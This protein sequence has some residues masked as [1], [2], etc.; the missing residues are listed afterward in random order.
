M[1]DPAGISARGLC[2]PF[3]STSRGSLLGQTTITDSPSGVAVGRS[4]RLCTAMSTLPS[5]TADSSALV[6]MPLPS[7]ARGASGITSPWLRITRTLG[8]MSGETLR[9]LASTS[10]VCASASRLPRVPTTILIHFS[11]AGLTRLGSPLRRTPRSISGCHRSARTAREWSPG[12]RGHPSWRQWGCE[13]AFARWPGSLPRCG[14][15][16]ALQGA[17]S[18]EASL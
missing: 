6:N 3:T 14:P 18:A 15:R 16:P 8:E 12:S 2:E 13:A 7:P 10:S 1:T 17:A 5:C 4:F 9:S 11:S